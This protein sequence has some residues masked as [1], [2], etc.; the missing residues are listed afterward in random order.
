MLPT[1]MSSSTVPPMSPSTVALRPTPLATAV[2]TTTTTT[3]LVGQ[4]Q[5]Q[6]PS[7]P[8]AA[9]CAVYMQLYLHAI[10]TK[11]NSNFLCGGKYTSNSDLHSLHL[12]TTT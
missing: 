6:K 9:W 11:F 4:T 7:G 8:L 2:T 5:K 1:I 10:I 3:Q 12:H